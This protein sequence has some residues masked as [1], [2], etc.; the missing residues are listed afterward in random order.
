MLA[1]DDRRKIAIISMLALGTSLLEAVTASSIAVFAQVLNDPSIGLNYLARLGI[2]G[3][4]NPADVLMLFAG[5]CG[6]VYLV[7]NIY[8]AFEIYRQNSSIQSMCYDFKNRLLGKYGF[9]DYA[10]Y[11]M[12]N[13]SYSSRVVGGDAEL[14]FSNAMVALAIIASETIVFAGL[15]AFII[16]LNPSLALLIFGLGAVI[17]LLTAKFVLPA[18]Y[19]WGKRRRMPA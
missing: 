17:A 13:S 9:S 14:V 2:D 8:A 16:Y 5:L 18:F 19:R 7:K 4:D 10:E 1:A 15:I 12:R 11:L 6:G 3:A